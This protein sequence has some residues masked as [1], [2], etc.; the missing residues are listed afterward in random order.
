MVTVIGAGLAGCEAALYL[1]RHGVPVTLLEQKPLHRSPAHHGDGFAE[2]V[3][4]NSLKA[5]RKGSSSGLL[6]MEMEMLGSETVRAAKQC[7]VPAGGALAVDRERFSELL[8]ERIKAE[9]LITVR[10]QQAD[11]LPEG[12]VIIATGPLTDGRFV[13]VIERLCGGRLSFFDA[14]APIVR[15]DS[16]DFSRAFF[17]ARYGRGTADYINCPMDEAEYSAFY[18]ALVSAEAVELKDFEKDGFRVYEGCMPVEIM[19]KRGKQTLLY[20]P[21]RPVGITDPATGRRPFAVVQLRAENRE[22]T[23]FNLVGFQTNLKFP[24]QKRV[25]SMIPALHGAAFV[26]Y[27]VMHRNTFIDS[28][29]VLNP[30]LSLKSDGRVFFAGQIT[31]VEGYM[32]SAACG[33]AAAVQCLR[34]IKGLPPF[35]FPADTMLGG[36]MGHI[37]N[38][39]TGDFQPM[40]SN[41]GLLPPLDPRIKGK[42]ERY[43]LLADRALASLSAALEKEDVK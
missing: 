18:D 38:D 42:Q 22:G 24:E 41:M 43:E 7:A 32:E 11:S 21:L 25:F 17:G 39:A 30:D 31:G 2:L 9:P 8:T 10:A 40:G 35:V 19:A 13:P 20:G 15:R 14:A 12:M 26:R 3:C 36:L 34:K 28:P 33:I 1:A 37:A 27:G 4:S 16:I 23:L 29:R 5:L 6:K